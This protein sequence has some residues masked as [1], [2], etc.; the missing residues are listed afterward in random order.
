M[1]VLMKGPGE[2][3][4][5]LIDRSGRTLA[6]QT[7]VLSGSPRIQAKVEVQLALNTKDGEVAVSPVL[8]KQ[9]HTITE[10]K[11]DEMP[12]GEFTQRRCKEIRCSSRITEDAVKGVVK[13]LKLAKPV[14]NV[15]QLAPER[16]SFSS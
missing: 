6:Q 13:P 9:S 4:L 5:S 7:F 1:E 15:V 11:F 8:L 16:L 14:K 2:L 12:A 10:V 3:T